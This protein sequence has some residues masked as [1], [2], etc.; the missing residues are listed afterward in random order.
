ML[1][2]FVVRKFTHFLGILVFTC[3]LLAYSG[4]TVA[5]QDGS[6]THYFADTGHNI[7][8]DFWAYYQGVQNAALV[9]G[10]PITEA[11]TDAQTG[12]LIQ[13]FQR[14]R[15]EFFPENPAGQRVMLSPVG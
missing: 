3:F 2:N 6:S 12:R 8:G 10:S 14:A 1:Y 5:A 4:G 13:Y 7:S 9:F 15:F 11:F